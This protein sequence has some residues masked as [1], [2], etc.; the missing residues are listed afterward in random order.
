M[1]FG[2]A[3]KNTGSTLTVARE[4][5]LDLVQLRTN[6]KTCDLLEAEVVTC[7]VRAHPRKIPAAPPPQ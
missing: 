4:I 7:F 6:L 1:A 5:C 3:S 2:G